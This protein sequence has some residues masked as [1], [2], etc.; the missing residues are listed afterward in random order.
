MMRNHSGDANGPFVSQK[1][2]LPQPRSLIKTYSLILSVDTSGD[3]KKSVRKHRLIRVF[4]G[5][6]YPAFDCHYIDLEKKM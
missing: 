4:T 2:R 3:T 5:R 6:T 1:I